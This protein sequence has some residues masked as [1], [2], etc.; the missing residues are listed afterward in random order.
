[1]L[2][3][4]RDGDEQ[5]WSQLYRSVASE[6]LSYLSAQGARD[7]EDVLGDVVLDLSRNLRRF[8]GNESQ[9]RGWVFTIAHHRVID[10]RRYWSRRPEDSVPDPAPSRVAPSAEDEALIDVNTARV[11]QALEQLT[12]EQRDVLL[13]RVVADLSLEQVANV[14]GKRTGAVKALQHRAL[15]ALRR[16]LEEGAVSL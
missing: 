16:L 3:A 13:L 6:L 11:T 2:D 14:L 9:L 7:P 1:M 10:Q 15:G 4:A 5:A 8:Q 12:V